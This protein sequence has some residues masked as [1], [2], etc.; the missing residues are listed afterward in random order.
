MGGDRTAAAGDQDV[1]LRSDVHSAEQTALALQSLAASLTRRNPWL[2]K[3]PLMRSIDALFEEIK[4]RDN[5]DAARF[6]EKLAAVR[7]AV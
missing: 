4:S 1:V 7:N 3:G 6:A 2:A 5:Y